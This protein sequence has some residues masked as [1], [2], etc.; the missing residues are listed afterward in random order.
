MRE[1]RETDPP[2]MGSV[3]AYV[4]RDK[5]RDLPT[6]AFLSC[7]LGWGEARKKAG[8]H[9]GFL[10]RRYDAFATECSAIVDHPPDDIWASQV[11]RGEPRLT[12][13][14]LQEGV[15]L[16]RLLWRKRLA[17]QIDD[18]F[19]M[20]DICND[21]GNFPSRQR[22]AFEMLTSLKVR[23]AFDIS[24]EESRTRER[25]G[26]T[27]FGASTLLARRLVERGVRF[28]NV[29]WDNYSKRFEVSKAA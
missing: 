27:L 8:S 25:Y 14:I 1:F 28:I 17:A 7:L 23:E 19:R 24:L 10:G 26:R 2:R 5:P 12:D 22:L 15:T 20:P 13:T 11:V 21:L 18:Q 3:C 6:Y 9:G 4:D 29:S 16:E